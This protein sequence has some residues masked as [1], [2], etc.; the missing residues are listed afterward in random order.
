MKS[1]RLLALELQEAQRIGD[2]VRAEELEWELFRAQT[3]A[4]S[5]REIEKYNEYKIS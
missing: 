4:E 1:I 3:D 2:E 5:M